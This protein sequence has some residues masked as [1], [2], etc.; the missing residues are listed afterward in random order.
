VAIVDRFLKDATWVAV[1]IPPGEWEQIARDLSAQNPELIFPDEYGD[2]VF[3]QA[4][5]MGGAEE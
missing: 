2:I 1:H 4:E 3:P 5:T